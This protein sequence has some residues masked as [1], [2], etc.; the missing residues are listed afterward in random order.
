MAETEPKYK[1]ASA[2]A[3]EQKYEEAIA[4]FKE[5]IDQSPEEDSLKISLAWVFRDS[6][7]TQEA[8]AL[9]EELLEKELSRKVF[10]GFAFDELVRIYKQMDNDQKLIE[11]CTKAVKVQP[12][13]VGLLFTLGESYRRCNRLNEAIEI[14]EKLVQMEPDSTAYLCSLGNALIASGNY[15][16]AE[17]RYNKAILIDP[18]GTGEY[19]YK[20]GN[21]YLEAGAYER[22]QSFLTKAIHH[23]EDQSLYYCVLGDAYLKNGNIEEAETAYEN[24]IRKN[25]DQRA[26]YYN[27]LGNMLTGEGRNPDA[28]RIFKKAIT[29]DSKN[30]FLYLHLAQAYLAEGFVAEAEEAYRKA[31]TLEEVF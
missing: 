23:K 19:Y 29:A 21:A 14:F 25:P 11:I 26:A 31:T 8:I 15:E 2:Y 22:A 10:T 6:G 20:M 28:I 1:L 30:P 16:E 12:E 17:D 3:A 4:L 9:F 13:D 5:L 18:E 27:R 7:R 24:A